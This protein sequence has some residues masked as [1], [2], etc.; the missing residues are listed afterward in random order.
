MQ[1]PWKRVAIAVVIVLVLIF[2]FFSSRKKERFETPQKCMTNQD[3][4]DGVCYELCREGFSA[5]GE[6]CYE[7]CKPGEKSEG[8]R[9]ISSDGASRSI[10]SYVRNPIIN[11]SIYEPII[12]CDEGYSYYSGICLE[13]C[14]DGFIKSGFVCLGNCPQN[15]KDVGIICADADT[16]ST[17]IKESYFPNTKFSKNKDTSN[18]V[19]AC[20]DGFTIN[21][22]TCI[23]NCPSNH[24]L[25]GTF[26]M[27]ICS[28][29]ETDLG[30]MCLKGQSLRP[31]L[32][33]IPL[34][35]T[36]SIKTT[37]T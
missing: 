25:N 30:T 17:V 4:I 5:I 32:V 23:E 14:K 18:V 35:T 26:C 20:N 29:D 8:M 12:E 21:G 31:K 7:V 16:Q 9:C 33:S 3:E 2:V 10:I 22:A 1:I 27:E 36:D 37:S 24:I 6:N 19:I 15:T 34:V 13:N 11:G 28:S